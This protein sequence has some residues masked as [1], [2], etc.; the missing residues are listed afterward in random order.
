MAPK[1]I[2]PG[3][4]TANL[5]EVAPT[6]RITPP[7]SFNTN[8]DMFGGAEARNTGRTA[9]ALGGVAAE[10]EKA[11]VTQEKR[12]LAKAEVAMQTDFASKE[13]EYSQ[14]KGQ[15]LLDRLDQDNYFG[16]DSAR[17]TSAN[18]AASSSAGADI[19][20]GPGNT[21][22]EVA[23]SK[24]A[25]QHNMAINKMRIEAQTLA[26]KRT[27]DSKIAGHHNNVSSAATSYVI[28]NDAGRFGTLLG[29]ELQGVEAAVTDPDIGLAAREGITDPDQIDLIVRSQKAAVYNNAI[30]QL[31]NDNAFDK[32]E[33]LLNEHMEADASGKPGI[34][35]GSKEAQQH[36]ATLA[37]YRDL[38]A[39]PTRYAEIVKAEGNDSVKVHKRILAITN[40]KL[41]ERL[42]AEMRMQNA[43]IAT[44]RSEVVKKGEAVWRAYEAKQSARGLIASPYTAPPEVRAA[45]VASLAN[46]RTAMQSY[47]EG[48]TTYATSGEQTYNSTFHGG[49]RGSGSEQMK[50]HYTRMSDRDLVNLVDNKDKSWDYARKHLSHGQAMA[51]EAKAAAAAEK[52]TNEATKDQNFNFVTFAKSI[53]LKGRRLNDLIG[54]T[55]MR[56]RINDVRVKHFKDT[57]ERAPKPLLEQEI[58]KFILR[59]EEFVEERTLLPDVTRRVNL[60]DHP[61]IG[62]LSSEE[63][64]T[65]PINAEETSDLKYNAS[66]LSV[67]FDAR[68]EDILKTMRELQEKDG[69]VTIRSVEKAGGFVRRGKTVVEST[70]ETVEVN[71]FLVSQGYIPEVI[72]EIK[73][74]WLKDPQNSG[75]IQHM[76]NES[77]NHYR[78]FLDHVK[79]SENYAKAYDAH[80]NSAKD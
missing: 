44:E 9:Q 19:V 12:E 71:D 49:E 56:Q 47:Y 57:S 45:Y 72:R 75:A 77:L 42:L 63:V 58:A 55:E 28:D 78:E 46:S 2:S 61:D 38:A 33:A 76:G 7:Q 34:L 69:E 16:V 27:I 1:I 18:L 68:K 64:E 66:V 25:M 70:R 43:A 67:L 11:L 26:D 8:V 36:L 54:S 59:T 24:Y 65:F 4:R 74:K 21:S 80:V 20:T 48:L 14:L 10:F 35:E 39:T 37:D 40:P 31:I 29:I 52:L 3:S 53:G 73:D 13:S 5:G 60:L 15:A 62:V 32:A 79:M 41:K 17:Q 51:V 22:L 6:A 30:Q 23:R 50:G